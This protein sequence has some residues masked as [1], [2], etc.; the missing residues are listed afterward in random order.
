MQKPTEESVVNP[1]ATEVEQDVNPWK[2]TA[3]SKGV[4]YL[5]L[6]EQFGSQLI[7]EKLLARFEKLT[8]RKPHRWL[9]RGYFFSHRS[10]SFS[11]FQLSFPPCVNL[12]Q[13]HSPPSLLIDHSTS[14]LIDTKR[15]IL[16]ISILGED[17]AVTPFI[18]DI[19]FPLSSP[20]E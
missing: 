14:C 11:F 2:V 17:Q 8:G 9:R 12:A 19:S 6:V 4:D 3:G 7:D 13:T 1:D 10:A 15:D 16:S 5:K 20:S 18:S